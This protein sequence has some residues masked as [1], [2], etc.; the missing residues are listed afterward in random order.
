MAAAYAKMCVHTIGNSCA[1]Y[2][3]PWLNKKEDS[4]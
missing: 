3:N 4:H 2:E 1:K